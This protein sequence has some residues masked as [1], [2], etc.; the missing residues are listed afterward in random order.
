VSRVA[1][2][3]GGATGIDLATVRRLRMLDVPGTPFDSQ[4]NNGHV[5]NLVGQSAKDY[6]WQKRGAG[7]VRILAV[8]PAL[9]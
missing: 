4:E 7:A 3:T 5:W 8:I 1:T 9:A 6:A 2:F